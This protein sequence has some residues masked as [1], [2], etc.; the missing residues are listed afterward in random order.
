MRGEVNEA[1]FT[2]N[3]LLKNNPFDVQ[4]KDATHEDREDG[5]AN[6]R[7][8]GLQPT[9]P[10]HT[11]PHCV[12]QI[13]HEYTALHLTR[14]S[15]DHC[16][17]IPWSNSVAL[18]ANHTLNTWTT[19]DRSKNGTMTPC[20]LSTTLEMCHIG[21]VLHRRSRGLELDLHWVFLQIMAHWDA[22]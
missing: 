6:R 3:A 17:P 9:I 7:S 12:P 19:S 5:L 13:L 20:G 4:E 14:G 8:S 1:Q 11:T 10:V 21:C 2:M 18:T 15:R 22:F 16:N